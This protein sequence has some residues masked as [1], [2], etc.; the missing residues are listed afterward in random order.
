MGVTYATE[1]TKTKDLVQTMSNAVEMTAI[2]SFDYTSRIDST[3][4]YVDKDKFKQLFP[5]NF[6]KTS[7]VNVSSPT[8]KYEFLE[9][10]SGVKAIRVTLQ[11]FE[12]TDYTST[13]AID[14][15]YE[16]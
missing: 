4:T 7:F 13:V 3:K 11:N 6:A 16:E 12:G 14:N 10:E 9:D 8:F 2:E 5:Q 15:N 1:D